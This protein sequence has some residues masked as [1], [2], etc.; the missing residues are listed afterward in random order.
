[1]RILIVGCGYVGLPLGERL[2]R[3]GHRVTGMRRSSAGDAEM[4]ARGIVPLHADITRPEDLAA[5]RPEFD[6]VVNV[7]SSTRGGAEDYHAVY[8]QGTRH[9]L[10]WLRPHPP[11]RYIYTSSTSVYGQNDGSVVTEESPAEPD[12]ETSRILRETEKVL[13]SRAEIPAI[14]LRTSGI[15]G[16]GRGH[17]FKQYLKGEAQLREDGAACINMV[18]VEDVAGA[19]QACLT[20]GPAPAV[21]NLTDD[22]PVTQLEFFQWLAARLNRPMPPSA[23]ADPNRKRGLTN[24]RL[25]NAKFK[26]ATGYRFTYP[27]FREGYAEEIA[28]LG[29]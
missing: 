20:A 26:A 24:K 15:Y 14:V 25:A 4:L 19:I 11:Q 17:L 8:L 3:A 1:M 12:S 21:Y 2:V 9:L 13:A 16:P 5:I 7:A 22:E 23:P 6:A 28:R 29:A 18:H 27:T 10:E